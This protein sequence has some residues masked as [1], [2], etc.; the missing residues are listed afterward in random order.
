MYFSLCLRATIKDLKYISIERRNNSFAMNV[1][2]IFVRVDSHYTIKG[3]SYNARKESSKHSYSGKNLTC[4]PPYKDL[5]LYLIT[6]F[7]VISI[8]ISLIN[9]RVVGWCQ[10]LSGQKHNLTSSIV[11]P[12]IVGNHQVLKILSW[13]VLLHTGSLWLD[14]FQSYRNIGFAKI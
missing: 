7:Q 5:S 12:Q 10:L 1:R 11:Q 13:H 6:F 2:R 3:L 8:L 9:I 14:L 4:P